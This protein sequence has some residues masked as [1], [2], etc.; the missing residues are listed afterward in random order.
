M[1]GKPFGSKIFGTV[2][3]VAHCRSYLSPPPV[4]RLAKQFACDTGIVM[5]AFSDSNVLSVS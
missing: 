5:F 2:N 1:Q 3:G 4:L